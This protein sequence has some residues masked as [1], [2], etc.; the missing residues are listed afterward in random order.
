MYPN[1]QDALPLPAR[2]DLEQYQKQA[3]DLTKA[4]RSGDPEAIGTWARQ[5][6]RALAAGM[7]SRDRLSEAGLDARGAQIAQFAHQVLRAKGTSACTLTNAQFV[8]ARA[9]GFASWPRLRRHIESSRDE[10]S[11][12]AAFE[13]AADA[14]VTGDIAP[15][16]R[17]LTRHPALVRARSTREHRATLLHYISANGVENYRQRTPPDIVAIA[18]LLLDRGADIEAQ[19]EVYGSGCTTLGL[20]A[21]SEPPRIAGQQRALIDLLL[22]R[23][24]RMDRPGMAGRGHHLVA[25]CL[26]NGQRAA[27]E[28]LARR[29]APLDRVSAAGLGRVEDVRR[30]IAEG[31]DSARALDEMFYTA[32]VHGQVAVVDELL[33]AGVA[34]DAELHGHGDGHTGLHVAAYHGHT[35]VVTRLLRAGARVDLADK[36]WGTTPLLWALTG[37]TRPSHRTNEAYY[38]I[39]AALVRAGTVVSRDVSEW[40]HARADPRMRAAL[41]GQPPV[42]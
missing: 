36:T 3:K 28:Y 23:G 26:A 40:E 37:W 22:E 38:D 6:L 21:T 11:L 17:L 30:A 9:H 42:T 39:V 14:I 41:S 5:W 29:G 13:A 7:E 10:Q 27:A 24:A 15:I 32:C 34:V 33:A 19:A 4:C 1:P 2:L 25:S 20:V 31:G 12:T 8:I 18:R 16:E 35:A